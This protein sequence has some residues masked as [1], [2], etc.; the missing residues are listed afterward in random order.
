M[1]Q[2]KQRIDWSEDRWRK[3]LICQRKFQWLEDT[4]AKLAAWMELKPGM[5]AVDVGCGLGFLGRAYWPYFGRGGRYFGVDVSPDLLGEAREAANEWAAKGEARFI[6]GDAHK[7]PFPSDSVDWA[8]CQTLLMHLEK[9]QSALAEMVRVVKP[10]G[11]VTCKEPDNLSSMLAKH[12][13]S[14]P[15]L[16]LEEL[17]LFA[18]V[19]MVSNSGRIKL[20]K[21]DHSIGPKVPHMMKKLGLTNIDI[22]LNDLVFHLD[23]PYEEPR[24]QHRLNIIKKALLEERTHMA[25][26]DSLLKEFL[27]GGGTPEEFERYREVDRRIMPIYRQQ[28]EKGKYF[29]CSSPNLYV[30]KGRKAGRV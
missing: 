23:P 2:D 10:G 14:V 8:I 16:D 25:F 26:M 30:I 3:V 4:V 7:L 6:A 12:Y 29:G 20:G 13:S 19:S 1:G 15:E 5:T 27:A 11:L 22:R 28:L 9:P 17:L 18:K 24:Q 21:G